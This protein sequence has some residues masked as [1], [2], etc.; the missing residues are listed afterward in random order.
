MSGVFLALNRSLMSL[1]RGRVWLYLLGPAL[2]ALLI[3]IGLSAVVL[4]QLVA[5][6]VEQPPMSWIT[7]WGAFWLAHLL[8]ALGGWLLILSASYLLAMILT[9]VVVLPLLLNYLAKT[10]YPELAQMGA[11]S[12]VGS[13]WNSLWA[14]LL[15]ILGWV[16][17][18]PLWLIPGMGLI[19]PLFWMAWLNRRTFA[20]DTLS[21][22]ATDDEWRAI[23]RQQAMP[24][25]VIG[26]LMAALAHVPFIGML[27]PSLA[28]LAYVHFC[29]EALR[30]L[31]Q[32]A[33]VTVTE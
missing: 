10:D 24:L 7:A 2:F 14:A 12:F 29:L 8:A 22:H 17:T 15:F 23:R 5:A 27:A 6:F 28:A 1:G 26:F 31:R 33:I 20:Y 21:L 11:D 3:M 25:L 30:Q 16:V 19:L 4:D 13:L 9:A 18:L 32:G